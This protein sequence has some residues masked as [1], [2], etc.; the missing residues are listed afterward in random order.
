VTDPATDPSWRPLAIEGAHEAAF[1]GELVVFVES[2]SQV[3]RVTGL[4]AA[5]WL[6][7]DGVTTVAAMAGELSGTL[8]AHHDVIREELPG[9]LRALHD[10]GLL[11]TSPAPTPVVTDGGGVIWPI[12]EP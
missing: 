5:A 1:D 8:R 2:T 7:C 6:L 4:A 9:A 11:S 3:H 10:A 12:A